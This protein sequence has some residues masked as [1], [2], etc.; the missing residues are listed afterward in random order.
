MILVP[1][2]NEQFKGSGDLRVKQKC[3]HRRWI[4]GISGSRKPCSAHYSDKNGHKTCAIV[5]PV[6]PFRKL[7]ITKIDREKEKNKCRKGEMRD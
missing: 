2:T 7:V 6:R 5:G 4:I 1:L 3:R